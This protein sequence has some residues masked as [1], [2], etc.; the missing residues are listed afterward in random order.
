M[1]RKPDTTITSCCT[2][3]GAATTLSIDPAEVVGQ[4]KKTLEKKVLKKGVAVR[5]TDESGNP[6]VL[7]R[8]VEINQGNQF[9][10]YLLP[11]IS[12]AYIE[13][14]G[15]VAATGFT[16]RPFH[17]VQKAQVGLFGGSARGMLKVCADRVSG[18]IA[19]DIL[20]ALKR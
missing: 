14:E 12:P 17:Y 18:K 19:A 9:L 20:K 2:L 10:R 5:W 16:S 6:D 8:V 7:I 15:Q 13:V 11:F 3:K 1:A 4:L